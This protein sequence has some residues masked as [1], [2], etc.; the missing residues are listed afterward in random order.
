MDT[1]KSTKIVEF[2][3]RICKRMLPFPP[4]ILKKTLEFSQPSLKKP[5]N[6]PYFWLSESSGPGSTRY[7]YHILEAEF[8]DGKSSPYFPLEGS[9]LVET[10]KSTKIVE[11]AGECSLFQQPSLKTL[12]FSMFLSIGAFKTGCC[13]LLLLLLLLAST[14][15]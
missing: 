12:G 8:G 6:F 14:L 13:M 9:K 1:R 15:I 4:A 3:R 7:E 11:F 2:N 5:W 10:R